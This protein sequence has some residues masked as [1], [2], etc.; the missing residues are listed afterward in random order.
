MRETDSGTPDDPHTF[1]DGG[2]VELRNAELL[3]WCSDHGPR[4]VYLLNMM[5][6]GD[7]QEPRGSFLASIGY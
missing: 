5:A 4:V 6:L 3:R 2:S 7:Y 1:H